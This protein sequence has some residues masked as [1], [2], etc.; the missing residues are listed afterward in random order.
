L[1][2]KSFFT[3]EELDGREKTNI[4]L[5]LSPHIGKM[6]DELCKRHDSDRTHMLRRLIEEAHQ[7]MLVGSTPLQELLEM[8]KT[9]QPQEV[10]GRV[11]GST[12]V[13]SQPGAEEVKPRR[14]RA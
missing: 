12:L 3:V 14:K 4:N 10:R 7:K 9:T 5:W 13:E 1:L 11:T 8:L 2:C 6:L